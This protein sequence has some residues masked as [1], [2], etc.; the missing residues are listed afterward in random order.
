M[1]T[2]LFGFAD[3][4]SVC[5]GWPTVAIPAYSAADGLLERT[6]AAL[7]AWRD[8][9]VQLSPADL[10]ALIR[11]ILVRQKMRGLVADLRV[12][13]SPGWPNAND[14]QAVDVV[15]SEAGE[16]G[17]HLFA[18]I[19]RLGWLERGADLYDD[20]YVERLSRSDHGVP[21]D[22]F[23]E[24]AVG[25]SQFRC[26]GQREAVRALFLMPD[27]FT[28]IANL[29]TGSGKSLVAQAP[30]LCEGW[31]GHLTL[32]VVP[33]VALA[34][35]QAR[36]M[37]A[38]LLRRYPGHSWGPLAYHSGLSSIE[39]R[40]VQESVRTGSQGILFTSPE[41]VEITLAGPLR[42]AVERG[43]LRYFV[44]DEAHLVGAWG[45]G[46][47]LAFQALSG[48]R[49]ELLS[50]AGSRP[51]KTALLSATLTGDTIELL[52]RLFG[53]AEKT[54]VISSMHVRPEPRFWYHKATNPYE[55]EQL[56]LEAIRK[57]P[58]PL[59]LYTTQ[60][61]SVEHWGTLLSA[62]GYQRF[63]RF[64]GGT[65]PSD[66]EQILTQWARGDL[67]IIVANSAF[68]LGVDKPDVRT[69]I[70]A[71]VPEGLDR[72]Y[73][74]VGRGGRDGA[75]CASLLV[76]I[77]GEFREARDLASPT[78]I[79]DDL[80]YERWRGLFNG[81]VRDQTRPDILM[82]NLDE[83]QSRLR[84]DSRGNRN[85]NI[86]TLLLMARSGL[87]ELVSASEGEVSD[88]EG[89]T[90]TAACRLR[91]L[92]PQHLDRGHWAAV[93][94]SGREQSYARAERAV[95]LLEDVLRGRQEI[96]AAVTNLYTVSAA[97]ATTTVT[98]CCGGC[99]DHWESRQRSV[100]Y[101]EP[102]TSVVTTI[103]RPDLN[104]WRQ[105][106]SQASDTELT[107]FYEPAQIAD[108]KL[109]TGI[110]IVLRNCP[111]QEVMTM[112]ALPEALSASIRQQLALLKRPIFCEPLGRGSPPLSLRFHH[113]GVRLSIIG[114]NVSKPL[115]LSD[116]A[117]S[118]YYQVIMMPEDQAD[119]HH[120]LRR[121][122]DTASHYLS[123]DDLIQRMT[124]L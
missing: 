84:Q 21:I 92:D 56:V 41:S 50:R 111:I 20:A 93:V 97:G 110:E 33:T 79:G 91:I 3:L 27:G 52:R 113:T 1:S 77:E 105:K 83:L 121:Y 74:E 106:V 80:G 116:V 87:V 59:I 98:S 71:T 28:L 46:F 17:Y 9:H 119:P 69:V 5:A 57:A 24:R 4:Q 90:Y 35:D 66:R 115:P 40:A 82:V 117:G 10:T 18:Q 103:A 49:R 47:R 118:C 34:L 14:W 76:W 11:Q 44:V 65:S 96:S 62:Q 81:A 51:F 123:L 73:Q 99:P 23:L 112:G 12:P 75:A 6:R 32:V 8:R 43:F 78:F 102:Q 42:N 95:S 48:F 26:A 55:R 25:F 104:E 72:F 16:G 31:E 7:V 39:K 29:P 107:I 13:R 124:V 15:A 109:R 64:H 58:R 70:H 89:G 61:A 94:Q 30:V 53:P 22:P 63:A 120:P 122:K 101:A 85:W 19:P 60:R 68:G 2:R 36:R 37:Q 38:L 45:D 54:Q 100:L 114:P 67:D 86:H 88:E 108:G